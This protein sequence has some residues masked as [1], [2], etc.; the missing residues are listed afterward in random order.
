MMTNLVML[1]GFTALKN[2][3]ITG[4]IGPIFFMVI[5][6]VSLTFLMQRQFRALFSFLGIVVIVSLFIFAGD[7]LFGDAGKLT[8]AGKSVAGTVGNTIN[9]LTRFR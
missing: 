6:G 2:L 8:A 7:Y 4:Y 5:A 1:N 3:I 9:Y